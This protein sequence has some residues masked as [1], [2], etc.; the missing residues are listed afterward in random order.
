MDCS[1]LFHCACL[2]FTLLLRTGLSANQEHSVVA[3]GNMELMNSF[4]TKLNDVKHYHSQTDVEGERGSGDV[5]AVEPFLIQ[6]T[7]GL[8]QQH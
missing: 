3:L 6:A 4:Y 7:A 1:L 5:V 8:R 2:P